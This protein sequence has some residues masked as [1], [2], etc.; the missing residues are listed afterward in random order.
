MVVFKKNSSKLLN[1]SSASTVEGNEKPKIGASTSLELVGSPGRRRGGVSGSLDSIQEGDGRNDSQRV[2]V[3]DQIPADIV[4]WISQSFR[5]EMVGILVSDMS[6]F[7]RLT[8][9]YGIIHFASVIIRM[10]QVCLPILHHFGAALITT[11][12]DDFIVIF[13]SAAAAVKAA[14]S[15]IFT[16]EKYNESLPPDRKHFALTLNGIGIDFGKGP[17]V[18]KNNKLHGKTFSNAYTLGEELSEKGCVLVSGNVRGAVQND[19]K[20]SHCNFEEV[21][22]E[23]AEEAIN[24]AS[25]VG[26]LYNYGMTYDDKPFSIP[27][28]DDNRYLQKDLVCLAQRHSPSLSIAELEI[29]DSNLKKKYMTERTV[30]MF[31]FDYGLGEDAE[32]QMRLEFE[33]LSGLNH[34]IEQFHGEEVEDVLYSF[35]DPVDAVLATIQIREKVE[36][37]Q[38]GVVHWGDPINTAS[39]LGQDL[40]EGGDIIVSDVIHDIVRADIRI[41]DVL[42]EPVELHKSKVTFNCYKVSRAASPKGEVRP[43]SV[44]ASRYCN[45]WDGL[46]PKCSC[47]TSCCDSTSESVFNPSEYTSSAPVISMQYNEEI[48]SKSL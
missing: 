17:L 33:C 20:F 25:E 10:R 6:G 2:S 4:Q 5:H 24:V 40:A 38:L 12:A 35:D 32:T 44:S 46:V 22:C 18:D 34:I 41:K 8:R 48:L 11:E 43:Q 3:H 9:T 13:R 31:E 15:M 39:K 42:F 14:H 19:P 7:T 30:L 45:W 23:E 26:G 27:G 21:S 29:L 1:K 36:L 28:V 16:V 37:W 47:A